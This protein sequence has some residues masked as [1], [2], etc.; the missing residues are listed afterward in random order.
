MTRFVV[1]TAAVCALT[2]VHAASAQ[3]DFSGELGIELRTFPQDPAYSGQDDAT[4][5]PSVSFQP[6][7]V[8]E[9]DEGVERVTVEAFLRWDADDNH[10]TH[11]DLREASYLHLADSWD[12]TI[13]ISRV[14]WGVTESVH[15]VDVINQTDG[16]EDIDSEDKLGQPMVNVNWLTGT[17][18]YSLFVLPG[19]RERTFP[20][21]DARRRGPYEIEQN[22]PL[23]ESGD[24]EQ[25]IDFAGRW[26][27]SVGNWDWGVSHF[28]GTNRE[29]RL[30]PEL[31]PSG[32]VRLRPY[33]EIMHQSGIDVQYTREAWLW[34]FESIYRE[35]ELDSYVAA[36]GGFEYTLY[37]VFE[38][39]AD[40]GLLLEYQFDDREDDGS[41][42]FTVADNDVFAGARLALNDES[43]TA[44]LAGLVYDL[45]HHSILGLVEAE[46]RLSNNW[47]FEIESRIITNADEEDPVYLFR[48]DDSLT[49]RLTYAF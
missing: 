14:F 31:G 12:L 33:Y 15:L 32:E 11:V 6:E 39:N 48:R 35:G 29:A 1:L 42:P 10:R 4:F 47:K 22:D 34:K 30:I 2:H 17:G 46:R 23:Y 9:W 36:V 26:S 28:Y 5:S 27:H 21:D 25:H 20:G 24:E 19:F 7:I 8:F 13:G 44:I 16:V 43:S 49:M 38:S 45:D 18:T 37:Q 40:L 41:A 3:W